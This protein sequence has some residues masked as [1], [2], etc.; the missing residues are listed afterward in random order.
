MTRIPIHDIWRS[1]SQSIGGLFAGDHFFEPPIVRLD[2]RVWA[3]FL[4][5]VSAQAG[6]PTETVY[7][8]MHCAYLPA[9]PFSLSLKPRPRRREMTPDCADGRPMTLGYDQVDASFHLCASDPYLA[10]TMLSFNDLPDLLAEQPT[11]SL[12][13]GSALWHSAQDPRIEAGDAERFEEIALR[14]EGVERNPR[15]LKA[16]FDMVRML[17]DQMETSGLAQAAMPDLDAPLRARYRRG[18]S[19][20]SRWGRV[21]IPEEPGD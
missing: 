1:L 8:V 14:Q 15:I 19:W 9:A 11:L 7:T 16:R 20:I 12:Q 13:I 10:R 17:L 3:I 6:G 5:V 18:G 2:H 21:P 4:T